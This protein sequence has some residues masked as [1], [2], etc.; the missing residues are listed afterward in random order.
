MAI[1]YGYRFA[2]CLSGAESPRIL[3]SSTRRDGTHPPTR[4]VV[5][6]RRY[7]VTL[8][9]N[10]LV[11]T[12]HVDCKWKSITPPPIRERSIAMSVSVCLCVCLS[13]IIS[14]ELHVRSSPT[15]L[16]TLHTLPWL[17]R[18]SSGGVTISYVLSVLWMTSLI[19]AHKPRLLDVA[20]QLKR[21]AHA[22]LCLAIDCAQ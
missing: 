7:D 15:F 20:A 8:R 5:N 14:S 21:S 16:C 13:A 12:T 17:G 4:C 19:I 9:C 1:T 2:S 11:G 18:S 22:A 3:H 6:I 10:P